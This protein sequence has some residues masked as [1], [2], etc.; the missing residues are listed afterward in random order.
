MAFRA[1][2]GETR[3][4]KGKEEGPPLRSE[5]LDAE[6]LY[7]HRFS[8]TVKRSKEKVWEVVVQEFFQRWVQADDVVVDLGCGY[9]EFLNNLRC[10]RRIGVDVNPESA[11]FLDPSIEFCQGD[12]A[13]PS[14][15]LSFVPDGTANLVFTSNMLEHLEGKH[16]IERLLTEVRRVLVPG[17]HFVAMGP[18]IRLLGG[19]YWDFWDHAIP[20]TD[21][22]L[23]ELL[24]YLDFEI[25]NRYPRFLPYTTQSKYP[26][27]PF[28]VKL[29]LRVPLAWRFL[30]KQFLVRARKK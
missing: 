22:S 28:F 12:M 17:G 18:N 21:R 6:K 19:Q 10:K 9:G 7:R 27:A 2:E 14:A 1:V 20:I 30:G 4:S 16:A 15:A 26:K 8:A 25:V 5:G 11:E 23:A 24:V 13:D 29:Y 3:L